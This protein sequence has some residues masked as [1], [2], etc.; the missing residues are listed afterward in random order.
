MNKTEEK[1]IYHYCR[2]EVMV[3][4][5]QRKQLWMTDISR[6]NDYKE[7]LLFI[8]GLFYAIDDEYQKNRFSFS[9]KGKRN[10]SAIQELLRDMSNWID[11]TRERGNLTSYVACFTENGDVLS[12]W[13]GYANNGMGCSLGFSVQELQKY[14]INHH[15]LLEI[16]PVKYI[17]KDEVEEIIQQ[18]AKEILVKIQNLRLEAESLLQNKQKKEDKEALLFF[19]SARIFENTVY[20]SLQYKMKSYEEEKEWRMY[21]SSITKDEKTLFSEKDISP[22]RKAFDR[23]W[24]VLH[25]KIEFHTKEDCLISYYPI[26][27]ME[28]SENPIKEIII[29]PKNKTYIQDVQLILAKE[30]IGKAIVCRSDIAYR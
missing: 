23:E 7:M 16:K 29:G 8:P 19:L 4:I 10:Y 25:G 20:E 3:S 12:Q 24:K 1:K 17:T 11:L 27:I 26:D 15:Q 2:N 9:Y 30:K 13:R 14:C 22:W 28:L 18:M 21:F 5:I 6:S